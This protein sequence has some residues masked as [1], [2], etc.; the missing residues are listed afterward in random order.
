MKYIKLLALMA[1]L[2]FSVLDAQEVD[3]WTSFGAGSDETITKIEQ[4]SKGN[5]IVLGTYDQIFDIDGNTLVI[6]G[7]QEFF[8]AKFSPTGNTLWVRSFT[9]VRADQGADLSIDDQD[10]IYLAAYFD[11]KVRVNDEAIFAEGGIDGLVMQITPAGF[12]GWIKNMGGAETSRALGIWVDATHVYAVGDFEGT[13][14]MEDFI[15]NSQ[16]GTDMWMAKIEKSEAL[17]S[18]V[19]SYGGTG[20]DRFTAIVKDFRDDLYVCGAS[21]STFIFGNQTF[22]AS[23]GEDVFVAKLTDEGSPIWTK[24]ATGD[25]EGNEALFMEVDEEANIYVSG[26]FANTLT[27]GGQSLNAGSDTDGFLL[28]YNANGGLRWTQHTQTSGAGRLNGLYILN[29]RLYVAGTAQNGTLFDEEVVSDAQGDLAF[30]AGLDL[31]GKLQRIGYFDG[32]GNEA[33]VDLSGRNENIAMIG[34]FEQS[35]DF[36]GETA[37]SVGGSDVFLARINAVSL[38]TDVEEVRQDFALEVRMDQ[39]AKR[40]SVVLPEAL[41]KANGTIHLWDQQ[42]RMIARKKAG[43]QTD[44][45]LNDEGAG[46]YYVQWSDG[47]RKISEA[48]MVY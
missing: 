31:D 2:P 10:V 23:S 47:R 9:G 21:S 40:L 8:L 44:F 38:T 11:S 19:K 13:G 17:I 28:S 33:G 12:N 22:T 35:L 43:V 20:D 14:K 18:W 32:P 46:V 4:D 24:Q 41:L 34:T 3:W 48:F 27:V 36:D 42:G 5:F 15:I 45:N 1:V 25:F 6:E 37:T 29:N 7:G 39:A 16:G 30:L 26:L